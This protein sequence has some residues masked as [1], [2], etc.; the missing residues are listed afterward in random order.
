MEVRFDEI[1]NKV[2]FRN[3]K[4]G[5]TYLDEE[6][7]LCIKVATEK[8]DEDRVAILVFLSGAWTSGY[9]HKLARVTKVRSILSVR[10]PEL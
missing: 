5:D 2:L 8:D 10:A 3:L 4:L 1:D 7:D 6:G 9:E